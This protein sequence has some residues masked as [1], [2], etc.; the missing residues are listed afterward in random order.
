MRRMQLTFDVKHS[1][2]VSGEFN[3]LRLTAVH[4]FLD[5]EIGN[6]KAVIRRLRLDVIDHLDLHGV[7]LVDHQSR[8]NEHLATF[9]LD[10]DHGKLLRAVSTC[11]WD[12][13]NGA[14]RDHA[15]KDSGERP[16]HLLHENPPVVKMFS[17][18][19][20]S[21]AFA[22]S[23]RRSEVRSQRIFPSF[24]PFDF[25][26]DRLCRSMN[27]SFSASILPPAP[28]ADHC[29]SPCYDAPLCNGTA[30]FPWSPTSNPKAINLRRSI[31]SPRG[32]IKG[33]NI[34]SCSA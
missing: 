11:A 30:P 26:Q 6:R 5:L 20:N 22:T 29:L 34:R 14:K 32:S 9:V 3:C 21:S 7:A 2:L 33:C 27:G 1:C 23:R 8:R 4:H 12:E 17:V 15:S 16:P 13:G 24:A 18:S 28:A 19:H 25:A 10:I 31:N